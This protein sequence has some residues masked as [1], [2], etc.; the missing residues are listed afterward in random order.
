MKRKNNSP[1][2]PIQILREQLR[3]RA[4]EQ[5]LLLSRSVS[6]LTSCDAQPCPEYGE[7]VAAEYET[8]DQLL[9]LQQCR[10]ALE[11]CLARGRS[12]LRYRWRDGR[13]SQT[14]FRRSA[15]GRVS[16][17]GLEPEKPAARPVRA[18]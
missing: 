8:I 17:S 13:V 9:Y 16:A 14:D 7:E 2:Y 12:R 1:E 11:R 4:Q 18:A 6:R 15:P 10:A 5:T 3:R